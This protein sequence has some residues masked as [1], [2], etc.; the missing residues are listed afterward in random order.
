MFE[1]SKVSF[2]GLPERKHNVDLFSAHGGHT[3]PSR[4]TVGFCLVCYWFG[5]MLFAGG[6][7]RT[8]T[9]G[10]FLHSA[11]IVKVLQ[12]FK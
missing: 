7:K 2:P 5:H 9:I 6:R 10:I 8:Q 12:Y 11:T 3:P 4:N 1:K